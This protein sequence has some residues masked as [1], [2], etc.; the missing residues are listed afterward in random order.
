LSLFRSGIFAIVFY[1][2]SAF[3]SPLYMP[4]MLGSRRFFWRCCLSWCRSCIWLIRIIL[5]IDYEVRGRENLTG[6]P[7]IIASKHQ[8]A[9]DTLIFNA[10]ILDCAYVVKRE[11]LWFP[12]FGWFLSRVGMIGIDRSGGASAL[13]RLV[14][15]C[16]QRLELG[17]SI[18]I[19]PQGTRTAPGAKR[20]YLPGT[21]ALYTQCKVP[22]VPTALNSGV[23]WP[24]RTFLKHPGTVIVEFLPPIAPG[25]N[26]RDFSA[27][28]EADIESATARIEQEAYEEYGYSPPPATD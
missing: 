7:V 3:M 24:R 23:F 1:A 28:L 4:L 26:R 6:E 10:I 5:G 18:I 2:W 25:M 13:K 15:D 9:W 22:V 17:R 16:K 20:P 14:A 27:R 19:F 12:F 21:A 11:L 8:S